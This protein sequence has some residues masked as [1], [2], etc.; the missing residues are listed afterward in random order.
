MAKSCESE[1]LIT[2]KTVNRRRH[3]LTVAI[4]GLVGAL[5]VIA[6]ISNSTPRRTVAISKELNVKALTPAE[7]REKELAECVVGFGAVGAV[8][9]P[10]KSSTHS[11]ISKELSDAEE[12]IHSLAPAS[13]PAIPTNAADKDSK[14]S[15]KAAK[16][17]EDEKVPAAVDSSTDKIAVE[18]AKPKNIDCACCH[19]KCQKSGLYKDPKMKS[20]SHSFWCVKKVRYKFWSIP[21]CTESR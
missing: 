15:A 19:S 4:T 5:V 14:K 20:I 17:P 2:G 12:V 1:G 7:K 10:G 3:A 9:C 8:L 13:I 16:S 11:L 6:V 21:T 18:A